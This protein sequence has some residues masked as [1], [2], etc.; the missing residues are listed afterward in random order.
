V[1]GAGVPIEPVLYGDP[2]ANA[3]IVL[4]HGWGGSAATMAVPSATLADAGYLAVAISMRGWGASG[5]IDD[6]GLHQPDDVSVI[7]DWVHGQLAAV[8]GSVGLLG[9]S[10]GGQVALLA[11]A[12]GASVSAVAAWAAVTDV[13]AWRAETQHPGIPGY[14]DETCADGDLEAR[15]PIIVAERLAHLPVL[16]VHGDSDTRV[17]TEQS[18]RLHAAIVRA[19]GRASL[20]VL[21]GI[22]HQR[23]PAGNRAALDAT[24]RFFATEL[25][26]GA[27]TSVARMG[28]GDR[29]EE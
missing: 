23:G 16:L 20:V 19:G 26:S 12:R 25:L 3:G 22:G 8:T 27:D 24:L 13:R 15:S 28:G 29:P 1:D 2:G 10:Q 7:V 4:V 11:A 21:E 14:I 9:I 17:P 18:R 5:G 6:C